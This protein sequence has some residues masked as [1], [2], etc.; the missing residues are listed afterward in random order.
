MGFQKFRSKVVTI[1][2]LQ[3]EDGKQDGDLARYVSDTVRYTEEGTVLIKTLE[4]TMEAKPGDWI[5]RGTEGELYPC[6][7]SVFQ[8][9]Y[10]DASKLSAGDFMALESHEDSLVRWHVGQESNP[11]ADKCFECTSESEARKAV[12][13]I[14][15]AVNKSSGEEEIVNELLSIVGAPDLDVAFKAIKGMRDELVKHSKYEE[16]KARGLSDAEARAEG[17]PEPRDP[18]FR[19]DADGKEQ[20]W[21]WDET[22]SE[23]YGPFDSHLKARDE[24]LKYALQL[25]DIGITK[26]DKLTPITEQLKQLITPTWDGNVVSKALRDKLVVLG[27]ASQKEGFNFLTASGVNACRVLGFLT[28]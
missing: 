8:R 2:A 14:N 13:I 27:H 11:P 5:I 21:F 10:E 1:E 15:D 3:H 6:K 23:K 19:E 26:D 24:C 7:D 28:E 18:V 9:K 22:W 4:G 20:W 25:D 17:R 16:A 12:Q